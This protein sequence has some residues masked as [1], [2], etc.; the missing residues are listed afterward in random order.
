MGVLTIY[1]IGER[2]ADIDFSLPY[3]SI[4]V[5][6]NILLTLMIVV[7]LILHGRRFPVATESTAGIGGLYKAIA[8]M[9]IESSALFAVTSLLVIGPMGAGSA[10]TSM[11]FPVL[12]ETQ[13]RTFPKLQSLGESPGVTADWTGHRPTTHHSAS[14]QQARVDEQYHRLRKRQ[15]IQS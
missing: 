12:A 13:V 4:S 3:F 5:S 11:F 14:R 10:V 8:A 7:R 6:L 2:K 1:P 9:L 15:S